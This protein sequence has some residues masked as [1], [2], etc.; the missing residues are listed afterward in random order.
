MLVKGVS[1][2][3]TMKVVVMAAA[4]KVVVGNSTDNWPLYQWIEEN[5]VL[6]L[7]T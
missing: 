1:S 3:D 6:A 2:K 7:A 4:A 5:G